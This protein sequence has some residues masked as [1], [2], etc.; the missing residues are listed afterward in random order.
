MAENDGKQQDGGQTP[1]KAPQDGK[2]PDLGPVPYER[3]KEVNEKAQALEA[4]LAEIEQAQKAAEEKTLAEQEKWRE[5]A[6]KR[7]AE[8]AQERTARLRMEVAAEAGLPAALAGR[9]RGDDREALVADAK[10][11]AELVKPVAPN[12]VPPVPPGGQDP[13]DLATMSP[14]EIRKHAQ[15][16]WGK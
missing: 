15:E 5:L 8:L 3:F 1:G 2:K 6:E 12:G 16:L 13:L 14:Q 7:A 4:R 11:L 9:L 10:A